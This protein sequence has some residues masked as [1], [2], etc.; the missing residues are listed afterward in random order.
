MDDNSRL[1]FS[2]SLEPA[3][4]IIYWSF[5]WLIFFSLLILVIETQVFSLALVSL[6][7]ILG[8]LLFYGSGSTLKIKNNTLKI[9]YFR[10]IKKRSLPLDEIKRITFS[11]KREISLFSNQDKEVYHI[12]LNVK[13]KKKFYDYLKKQAP[14]IQLEEQNKWDELSK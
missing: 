13:N 9:C 8:V 3:F 7:I 6:V 12:Y 1:K 4:Q 2:L 10:G 14:L 11:A 5:C